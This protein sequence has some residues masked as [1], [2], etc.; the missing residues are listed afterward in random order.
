MIETLAWVAAALAFLPLAVGALNLPLYRRLAHDTSGDLPGVSILVPARNEADTIGACLDAARANDHQPLEIVVMDDDSDDATAEIVERH[1]RRDPRVELRRASRLPEGWNGKQHA[2]AE[3]ARCAE[4]PILLFLDAD[5][6]LAPDAATRIAAAFSRGDL[7]LSS[8][9]PRQRTG[10]LAERLVIP[11]IQ[12]VLLGFLPLP[13]ARLS[14]RPAFAA[15]CGQLMA[16]RRSTYEASGGHA[17][18]RAS[19]HDGLD[20]PRTIRRHGGRADLFDATDVASCRMYR[21]PAEV[22]NGL[23]KN[24]TEGLGNPR[25][26][27]FWTALLLGGQVLPAVFLAFALLAGSPP[28]GLPAAVGVSAGL[29]FRLLLARRFGDSVS[30][31]LGHPIG[32]AMLI[33]AQWIALGKQLVGRPTAWKGR[34]DTLSPAR[35]ELASRRRAD[36]TS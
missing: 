33:G 5:V 19:R 17:T 32:V 14:R 13:L 2:C 24:A 8:G 27:G 23:T 12:F 22:W 15:G 3:L 29:A 26:I 31:V 28:V 18:I 1:A 36:S 4:Q 35:Q 21:G 6:E 30:G 7:D 34:H 16:V 10:S 9:V 20:L 25:V 11:L